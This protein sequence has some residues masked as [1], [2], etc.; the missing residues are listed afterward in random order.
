MPG[1]SWC[2]RYRQGSPGSS[3]E[4]GFHG[5]YVDGHLLYIRAGTLFS[6]PFDAERLELRGEHTPIVEEVLA[7][8]HTG[9][10][11]FSVSDSGTLLYVPG[12]FVGE[13][14]PVTW[15]DRQGRTSLLRADATDW[16]SPHF[17]PKG[18]QLAMTIAIRCRLG[19]VDLRVGPR[20]GDAA[21]VRTRYRQLA[22]VDTGWRNDCLR[23]RSG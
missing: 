9:S 20:S 17:S 15:I 3:S 1:R 13:Q 4:G 23:V 22:G 18:E 19:C 14:L 2:S 21:H 6:V 5:R 7:A 10:A 12:K 11:Q 8:G 16:S